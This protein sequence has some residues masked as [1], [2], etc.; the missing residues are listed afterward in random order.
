MIK[1]MKL[2]YTTGDGFNHGGKEDET[3][4]KPEAR[5]TP[6]IYYIVNI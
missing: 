1:K 2:G 4:N 5:E 3:L 6:V